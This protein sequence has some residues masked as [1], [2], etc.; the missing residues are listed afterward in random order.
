MNKHKGKIVRK[1]INKLGIKIKEVANKSNISRGTLYN[2]FKE[3]DLDNKVLLKLGKVLRYDFSIHFPELIPLKEEIEQKN[4]LELYGERTT[5]E[6]AEIQ[7]KYY[8]LLEKHNTL[9][10]FLIKI[11]VDYELDGLREELSHFK[12]LHLKDE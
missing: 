5:E 1:T 11:A 9:L 3:P 8:K 7:R 10:K 4:D 2:Y 6:L 12:V